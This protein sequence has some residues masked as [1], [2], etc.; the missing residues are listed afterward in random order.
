MNEF[1]EIVDQ[2]FECAR[3]LNEMG[4][5]AIAMADSGDS[6]YVSKHCSLSRSLGIMDLTRANILSSSIGHHECEEDIEDD[7]PFDLDSE[8]N[9]WTDD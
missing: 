5:D 6:L 9:E 3:K 1:E 4:Y 2:M 8:G 7:N